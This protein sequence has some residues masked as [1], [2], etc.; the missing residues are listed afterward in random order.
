MLGIVLVFAGVG[1]G[2]AD[3]KSADLYILRPLDKPG[4]PSAAGQTVNPIDAFIGQQYR[5]KGLKP[6]G[7]ADK[8]TLLRR[9]YLD[10]I[11]IPPTPGEQDAF[12]NDTSPG[13]YE[14]VVDRLL[15][16][17]QHGVRY[18]RH[19]LDVLRYADVDERMTAAPGIYLWR[20]WVIRAL[21]DDLPFDQFVRAQLT[22]YRSTARTQISATGYRSRVEQRPDDVFALGFLARGQVLRDGKDGQELALSAVDTV[23]TAFM[24]LTVGCAKCHNH[25]F[26]PISERDF[27]SMK[28][29]FD[30]LV[31]RK[32]WLG[33]PEQVFASGRAADESEKKKAEVQKSIDALVGPYKKKLFDDRVAMLPPEAQ[34]VIRKPEAQRSVSEQKLADDYY[35]IVRID[36]DKIVEILP[37]DVKQKYQALQRQL[38]QITGGNDPAAGGRRGAGVP[39]FWTVEVDP[40]RELEKSYVLTSGDA[41]RPEMD[42]PVDP[43]WPFGPKHIDFRDGRVEAF[44]D[45]LTAPQNPM[46]ARVAMN[47][48][49]QWHFG[50]GLQKNSSDFGKLSGL[51]SNPQ[52]LDWLA[53][54]F[55]DRGF[56]MKQMHRLIV[57]SETYKL[58]SQAGESQIAGNSADP[59]NTYLWHYRLERLE[60]EPIWDSIFAAAGTLDTAVGGPSFDVAGGAG[61]RRGGGAGS[62]RGGMAVANT[63][64]TRRAAYMIRGFSTSRDV[65][66]VFLQAFDVDDGRVPCPLR[67]QTVTAPQGLF[68][69]NSAEIEKASDGF[70]QRIAKESDGNLDKAVDRAYRLTLSRPPSESEMQRSLAYLENDPSRLKSF[71][72]IMFNLDEFIYVR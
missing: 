26:D 54:E 16:S 5:E 17:E 59:S 12:V 67:T 2:T 66:P 3:E 41:L 39:T 63:S 43:G 11:G 48:M 44:S 69:M 1:W 7:R 29:L 30:P 23:S 28:A 24:G 68:M 56:S 46:F 70:A 33:T 27:Y 49:W 42:H 10:L 72:W 4:V 65:V 60:A 25:K 8:R 53:C 51:P 55:V 61:G 71:A 57:T 38:T 34:A 15:T 58:A 64:G 14:R 6:V 62:R 47:R 13:A 22:G 52:L 50:E 32:L 36:S 37:A 31:V 35:P 21:N 45:W 9:V 20:D 40:K 19:W 18:G